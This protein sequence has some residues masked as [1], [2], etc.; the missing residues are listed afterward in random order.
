VETLQGLVARSAPSVFRVCGASS[1]LWINET[2]V[3]YGLTP[4]ATYVTDIVSLIGLYR[5]AVHGYILCNADDESAN[6]AIALCA[7]LDA[8]AVPA[9]AVSIAQAAQ[10]PQLMDVRG[11]TEQTAWDKMLGGNCSRRIVVHQAPQQ[12]A[13]GGAPPRSRRA[14]AAGARIW[15]TTRRWR[16]RLASRQRWTTRSPPKCLRASFSSL[17]VCVR[18]SV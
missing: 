2:A 9:D 11:V 8:I 16:A 6:V 14:A 4:N 10:L 1:A 15:A 17:S 3:L 13:P 12:C 7:S 5:H 18:V